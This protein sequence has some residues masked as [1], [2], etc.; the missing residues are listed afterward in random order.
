MFYTQEFDKDE[1]CKKIK[2]IIS[3]IPSG[4]VCT[5]G[6]IALLAGRPR[7]SRMVGRFLSSGEADGLPAHRVVNHRGRTVPGWLEQKFLLEKEKVVFKKNGCVDL[8]SCMW[9]FFVDN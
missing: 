7:N 9:E 1:F 5:Y 6:M 4:K 8:K 2:D 3:D